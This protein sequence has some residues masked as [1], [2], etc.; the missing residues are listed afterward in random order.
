M[1]PIR[2]VLMW[3]RFFLR[4]ASPLSFNTTPPAACPLQTMLQVPTKGSTVLKPTCLRSFLLASE[5]PGIRGPSLPLSM[6]LPNLLIPELVPRRAS[7]E[8]KRVLAWKEGASNLSIVAWNCQDSLYRRP[9]YKSKGCAPSIHAGEHPISTIVP[10]HVRDSLHPRSPCQPNGWTAFIRSDAKPYYY[11]KG[12]AG[13]TVITEAD[14][15]DSRVSAKLD[16][17]LAVIQDLATEKHVHLPETSDLFLKFDLDS[18]A[19]YYY[20][21]DHDRRTIL[22]L[23]ALETITP[24]F[25]VSNSASHLREFLF[26]FRLAKRIEVFVVRILSK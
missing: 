8:Q 5:R 25:P 3:H 11:K 26:H 18:G 2:G 16:D 13:I 21:A 19:C 1:Q 9:P 7:F 20:L 14:V 24:M 22:W 4:P 12:I 10:R 17:W 6:P 15:T 23:H